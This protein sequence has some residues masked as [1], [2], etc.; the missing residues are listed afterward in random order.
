MIRVFFLLISYKLTTDIIYDIV[1]LIM[2]GSF[3][4]QNL[5]NATLPPILLLIY[6]YNAFSGLLSDVPL[7]LKVKNYYGVY[8]LSCILL[9]RYLPE[10]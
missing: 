7:N 10:K 6:L 2:H 9:L 3:K 1:F 5:S 4:E 8:R